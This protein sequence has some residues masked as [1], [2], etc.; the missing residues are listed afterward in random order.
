MF[1]GSNR[2]QMSLIEIRASLRGADCHHIYA[3]R[4]T[5][6]AASQE[7]VTA[8]PRGAFKP[9]TLARQVHAS[10]FEMSLLSRFFSFKP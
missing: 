10:D 6:Q 9:L 7:Q 1:F 2:R 3:L 5:I 8:Y 4:R